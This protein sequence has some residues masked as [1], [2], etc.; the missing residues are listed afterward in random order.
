MDFG[1]FE[2]FW[3]WL[4]LTRLN[5]HEEMPVEAILARV[6]GVWRT[7]VVCNLLRERAIELASR[8]QY[9]LAEDPEGQVQFLE[10]QTWCNRH[11]WFFKEVASPQTRGRLHRGLH[12]RLEG[13]IGELLRRSMAVEA[14]R[15]A[16]RPSSSA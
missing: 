7:C 13:R 6:L 2:E 8:W 12:A 3:R 10:S 16:A 9:V 4:A 1:Q 14:S 11:A 5:A 15:R